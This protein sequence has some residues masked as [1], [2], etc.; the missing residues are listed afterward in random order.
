MN[1]EYVYF[2][3]EEQANTFL[4]ECLDRGIYAKKT[5]SLGL[6]GVEIDVEKTC[7]QKNTIC[8]MVQENINRR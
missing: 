8:D 3:T 4:L 6:P 5:Y 7:C 2:D 1:I